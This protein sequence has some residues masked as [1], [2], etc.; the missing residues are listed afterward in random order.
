MVRLALIVTLAVT[1]PPRFAFNELLAR[2]N[3]AFAYCP[4]AFCEI[5]AALAWSNDAFVFI[6][7]EFACMNAA[8][9]Y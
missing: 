3:A 8:F 2:I 9:A 6:K 5:Y 7:L 1:V 4:V